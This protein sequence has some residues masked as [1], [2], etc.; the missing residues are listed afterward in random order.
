MQEIS[1]QLAAADAPR[2]IA[3]LSSAQPDLGFHSIECDEK[4][5]SV[6]A[7]GR[8]L[9]TDP[10]AVLEFV[11]AVHSAGAQACSL[12]VTDTAISATTDAAALPAVVR[13]LHASFG[14][15]R[16]PVGVSSVLVAGS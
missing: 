10:A 7:I 9:R 3:A 12:S 5:G 14:L 1:V 15:D 6:S 2:A 13:S 8:G 4:L 11:Q 16:A